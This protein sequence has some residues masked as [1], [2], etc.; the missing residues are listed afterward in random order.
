MAASKYIF[1]TAYCLRKV[2]FY[3]AASL[4]VLASSAFMDRQYSSAQT[5]MG[6]SAIQSDYVDG[7]VRSGSDFIIQA[8]LK[9]SLDVD[10]HNFYDQEAVQSYYRNNG[11]NAYWAAD[12]Q[13]LSVVNDIV[14]FLSDSWKQGL[15]PTDYH[16]D[17]I[18]RVVQDAQVGQG[19]R[20]DHIKA[21][22]ELDLLIT[23]AV[24][25]YV[26]DV[27]GARVSPQVI[28]SKDEYWRR[29]VA[30]SMVLS[31]LSKG[32]SPVDVMKSYE[33]NSGLYKRLQVELVNLV[34]ELERVGAHDPASLIE[35][36]GAFLKKGQRHKAVEKIRDRLDVKQPEGAQ[37]YYF[38]HKLEL[39]VRVF[40]RQHGLDV[41][42]LVG[43]NTL[44]VMNRSIEDE[45]DQILVNLERIRW[46]EPERPDRFVLVNVPSATLWAV[47]NGKVA[48]EMPV[49]VG[50]P[51]R[52]TKIFHSTVT[53]VRFN[54]TWTVP[55]S[56]K[57]RDIVP[58]VIKD[59]NYLL[60]KGMALFHGYGSNSVSVNPLD[61]DWQNISDD[62]LRQL[63]MVQSPGDHN[64]LGRIRVLMPNKYN[65]YLHDTNHPEYFARD[66]RAQSSGCIRLSDPNKMARFVL[67][68]DDSWNQG[69]IDGVIEDGV[70]QDVRSANKMPVY[71][72]YQ[73]V[74]VG[75]DGALV[76][77]H[78]IYGH[79]KRMARV[80]KDQNKT[81][82]PKKNTIELAAR[83]TF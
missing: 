42:G 53:G 47:D 6:S 26:S 74:W 31:R 33:P 77:G 25:R 51:S 39:A 28:G 19:A 7:V 43:G 67:S 40:Q 54:P 59:P 22:V 12:G 79:D 10:S 83:A 27:T 49:V 3:S 23:D 80:L 66:N 9:A 82:L 11:F 62:D 64:A 41:D 60:D 69:R 45:I 46:I 35:I 44:K 63:R 78:D 17:E 34:Q 14:V 21:R 18:R 70:M 38:D 24:I 58:D 20:N 5:H 65:I 72:Y 8:G 16:V 57:K 55:F 50:K 56:I 75:G 36:Q 29:P 15:N 13:D 1:R 81:Y 61:V 68:Q 71:I 30:S 4:F 73:T 32:E 48:F 52:K 2:S 37:R 76:Y